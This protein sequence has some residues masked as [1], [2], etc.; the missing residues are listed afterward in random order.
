LIRKTFLVNIKGLARI[1]PIGKYAKLRELKVSAV[2][3]KQQ[4]V[5]E[6]V[7]TTLAVIFA[8]L[9]V[10]YS[11]RRYYR[12]KRRKFRAFYLTY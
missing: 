7:L 2:F 6:F 10:A 8:E 4:E 1:M 5:D 9:F 11:K 3:F 12:V